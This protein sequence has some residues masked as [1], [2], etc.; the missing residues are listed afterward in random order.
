[1]FW[2]PSY[3][4]D[5]RVA[6]KRALPVAEADRLMGTKLSCKGIHLPK[7]PSPKV[8]SGRA[9]EFWHAAYE[10]ALKYYG[11]EDGENATDTAKKT[12]WKS[13]RMFFVEQRGQWILRPALPPPG[14]GPTSF[15]G[16]PGDLEQLGVCIEYTFVDGDANL[17]IRRFPKDD[18]PY[19]YWSH[20]H[21][22]CY[23][24]PGAERGQ[25]QPP[26]LRSES[27]KIFKRWAQRPARCLRMVDVPEINLQLDGMFDTVVYASDKW[28]DPNPDERMSGSQEYIHQVG[29]GVGL[30]QGKGKV[31]PA[32]VFT[33]GC[34]ELDERGLIH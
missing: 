20:R 26:D 29:D 18:P 6:V 12:A 9:A 11:G 15:I 28:H 14:K 32:I 13:L 5:Y 8:L 22:T 24:F 23:V 7:D 34:M 4:A 3:H 33:G 2:R 10:N 1:M 27:A 30:W 31:P 17:Q 16:N 21:R 25:C 19:L